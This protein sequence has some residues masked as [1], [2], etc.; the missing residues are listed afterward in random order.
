VTQD[1]ACGQLLVV[2]DDAA[3]Q[4]VLQDVLTTAGYSVSTVD[5]GTRALDHMRAEAPDLVVLDLMLPD[6]DGWT[7]LRLRE[8]E[9]DLAKVPVL[10]VSA[11]SPQGLAE[12]RQ[13]GAPILLTK[14]FDVDALLGVVGRLCSGDVRQCAWCR[15]VMDDQGSYELNTD[16]RLRWA[17]H[18]I[19]PSCKRRE[20]EELLTD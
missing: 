5:T 11:A 4:A 12:A 3:I 19:C 6:M 16:R 7:F 15:R 13:L 14:P 20:Q 9:R 8:R 17:T 10:V 2:E 18:G 1:R